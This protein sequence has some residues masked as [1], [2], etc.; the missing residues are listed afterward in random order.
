MPVPNFQFEKRKRE[1]A[2]KAKKEAK[3]L[4]LEKS[5]AS[6]STE[7]PEPA[8]VPEGAQEGTPK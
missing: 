8:S 6:D 1:L 2:K 4:K 5:H 7:L 3:R